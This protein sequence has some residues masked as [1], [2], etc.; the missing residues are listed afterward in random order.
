V[1][2][3]FFTTIN[4]LNKQGL[5]SAYHDRSDGGV[6]TTLLEMAF[7]SH[8]GL[9]IVNDDI[10][11][12]FN[13][14]LGCVIQVSN[15]NKAAVI[16]ALSKAGLAKC[17]HTIAKINNTDTINIG[18]F[19]KQRSALQQLWSKTSYEIVKLRDNP[20]RAKEEF[21]AIA[22]DTLGLKNLQMLL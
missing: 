9:D 12:L 4:Q 19:S 18:D 15:T 5:I 11:A 6:I 13:E 10:S 22:Q 20:E 21:D 16:N 17:I 3:N 7:A 1:F 2:K 14:E 8:C